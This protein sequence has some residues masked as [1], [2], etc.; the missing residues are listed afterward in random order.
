MRNVNS[1]L[2][3]R[4]ELECQAWQNNNSGI[5]AGNNDGLLCQCLG[6]VC[7]K[8]FSQTGRELAELACQSF[9]TLGSKF[10]GRGISL[11]QIE[12]GRMIQPWAENTFQCRMYLGQQAA[13]TVAGLRCLC[14]K[15]IIE[16]TDHGE[17]AANFSNDGCVTSISFGFTGV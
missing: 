6:D 12:H 7:S 2:T 5:C 1:L 17:F 4:D 8:A 3:Q 11:E 9:L 13:D 16:A 15:I 14:G 10:F